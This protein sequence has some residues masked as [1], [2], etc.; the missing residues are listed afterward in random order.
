MNYFSS[1]VGFTNFVV[2]STG[3]SGAEQSMECQLCENDV[4]VIVVAA[5]IDVVVFV[6]GGG[7]MPLLHGTMRK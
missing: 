5:V 6:V 2:W 4:F 1:D 7:G 3:Q